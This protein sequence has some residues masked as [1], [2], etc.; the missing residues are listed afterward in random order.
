MTGLD[1]RDMAEGAARFSDRAADGLDDGI[2]R[3][4]LVLGTISRFDLPI[5]SLTIGSNPDLLTV[6]QPTCIL[7]V[8]TWLP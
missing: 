7:I 8:D 6:V 2:E 5:V 3:H 1:Q 4:V